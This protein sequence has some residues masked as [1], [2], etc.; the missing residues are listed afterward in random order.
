M[1]YRVEELAS[2]IVVLTLRKVLG[3]SI[4]RLGEL[5]LPSRHDE[6]ATSLFIIKT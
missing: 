4:K 6:H 3:P 1:A 2:F 5:V